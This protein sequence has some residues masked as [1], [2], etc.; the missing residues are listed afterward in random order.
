MPSDCSSRIALDAGRGQQPH[1]VDLAA[2][3]QRRLHRADRAG[4]AVAAGGRD[5]GARATR[6]SAGSVG[7]ERAAQRACA[8]A[9][10]SGSMPSSASSGGGGITSATRS[11]LGRGQPDVE[12][13]AER[14]GDL[15][16]EERAD[17]CA[18]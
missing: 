3:G 10:A 2:A 1:A 15:L 9:M 16:G 7:V 11:V 17:D 8:P 13:G 4:V 12:V 6:G 14:P 18:R 5:L